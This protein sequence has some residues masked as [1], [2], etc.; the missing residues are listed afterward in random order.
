[1]DFA[2][3]DFKGETVSPTISMLSELVLSYYRGNSG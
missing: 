1:M 3:T 2:E